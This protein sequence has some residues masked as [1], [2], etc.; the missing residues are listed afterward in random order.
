MIKQEKHVGFITFTWKC[1]YSGRH[2][3]HMDMDM[4]LLQSHA[5]AKLHIGEEQPTPFI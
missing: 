5:A 4:H 2:L 1:T 3:S